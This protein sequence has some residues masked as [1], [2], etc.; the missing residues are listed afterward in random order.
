MGASLSYKTEDII[1]NHYGHLTVTK[2]D[3]AKVV[4]SRTYRYFECSCDCGNTIIKR[5]EELQHATEYTSCG[6]ARTEYAKKYFKPPDQDLIDY[7]GI[8]IGMLVGTGRKQR[9]GPP[10]D[11][12]RG[13]KPPAWHWEFKC[14]CGN[15]VWRTNANIRGHRNKCPD[16]IYSC[17]CITKENKT[18]GGLQG[19]GD[20]AHGLSKSRIYHT[21]NKMR[22]RCDPNRAKGHDYDNYAARGIRVCVEW[23]DPND[24]NGSFRRFYDWAMAN[25]YRDDLTIDRK[26]NDGPYA[27]WNCRWVTQEVQNN[28]KRNNRHIMYNDVIYTFSEFSVKYQKNPKI[29]SSWAA[30]GYSANMIVHNMIHPDD[31]LTL[32]KNGDVVDRY[33]FQRLVHNYGAKYLE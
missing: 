17:G 10:A 21:W 24:I 7:T 28:N 2:L 8:R 18:L 19:H 11:G 13:K 32:N 30:K 29:V 9:M 27:P 15:T 6:C 20:N 31:M 26:D 33:G 16:R 5:F 4:G 1:G 22:K 14:D 3:H 25:G 12:K 23:D